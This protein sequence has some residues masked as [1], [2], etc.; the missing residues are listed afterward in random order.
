MLSWKLLAPVAVALVGGG[1]TATTL[2]SQLGFSCI[3]PWYKDTT[4][5]IPPMTLPPGGQLQVLIN[6][7]T[8]NGQK[9]DRICPI[10]RAFDAKNDKEV[11]G[12]CDACNNA[13]C[14]FDNPS[15]NAEQVVYV[16][17]ST[18]TTEEVDL[19]GECRVVK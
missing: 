17:F 3:V 5:G 7:V 13:L 14:P 18:R 16:K 11:G 1:I 9:Y 15:R 4:C 6:A 12:K 19:R 8:K 2:V 10:V